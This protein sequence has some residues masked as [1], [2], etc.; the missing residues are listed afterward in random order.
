MYVG[1]RLKEEDEEEQRRGG[2]GGTWRHG[3]WGS[4]PASAGVWDSSGGVVGEIFHAI[5]LRN[6]TGTW[7]SNI[8]RARSTCML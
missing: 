7:I 6:P 8:S 3:A 5:G 1:E 4:G 2:G